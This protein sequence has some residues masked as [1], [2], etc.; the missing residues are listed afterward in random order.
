MSQSIQRWLSSFPSLF[1]DI[2]SQA[3]LLEHDIEVE[4]AKPIK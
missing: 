3:H 1:G 4:E 2:I